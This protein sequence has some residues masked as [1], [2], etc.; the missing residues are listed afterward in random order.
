MVRRLPLVTDHHL[1]WPEQPGPLLPPILVE[2]PAWYTWL[3]AEPNR[4]FT[5][6]NQ[7]GT[8]TVRCEQRRQACYWYAY[9]KHQGRLH[10]AYLG[11]TEALTLA[12]LNAVTAELAS[13]STLRPGVMFSGPEP[14]ARARPRRAARPDHPRRARSAGPATFT[15]SPAAGFRGQ[16]HLPVPLTPLIGREQDVQA[17]ATLLRRSDIRL[18]TLTGAGGIGKTRLA[19]QVAASVLPDFADG[20]CYVSLAL[21]HD[22]AL[23]L[24][25][26]A[27]TLGL[28]EMGNRAEPAS[29]HAQLG[30]QQLLLVL[31]NFEQVVDAA[32]LLVELVGN[33]PQ[34]TILVTSRSI[35]R[36]PGEQEYPVAPLALPDLGHPADPA[37]LT[38]YAAVALF[39]ARAQ[40]RQ[41]AFQMTSANAGPIAEICIRL[42]GLP[43]AIELA[44][45]RVNVLTPEQI[46]ARLNDACRLLTGGART[47]LPRQQ[48]LRATLDWSYRLLTE[49]EQTVFRRLC[50]FAG[51]W[52]LAAAEAICAGEGIGEEQILTLLTLLIDHSL[53]STVECGGEVRYRLLAIIQQYGQ[54]QQQALGEVVI[55][56]RR[57]RDWYLALAEQA[58]PELVSRHQAAWLARLEAEHDN[59]R[60]ALR[61]SLDQHEGDA[62]AQISAALWSFWLLRGYLSEGRQWLDQAVAARPAQAVVRARVLLA[63]GSI[64]GRLGDYQRATSL[65]EE[66]LALWRTLG[67]QQR[68]AFTLSSL[69]IGAQ[70]QGDYAQA[71]A[72][73]EESLALARAGGDPQTTAL[74]LTNLGLVVFY[75]GNH[76]RARTLSEQG[77]ALFQDVGDQRGSAAVLTNLGMLSLAQGDYEQARRRA[78][79]SLA[80]R[81]EVGDK[82][83]SAHTL[84]LL[85]HV[86]FAQGQYDQ[87]ATCYTESR[88]LRQELGEPDGVAAALEGLAAICAVGGK[89]Q[90]AARLLGAAET[91]REAGGVAVP[92]LERTFQERLRAR[93]QAHLGVRAFAAACAEGRQLP[94]DQA[95]AYQVPPAAAPPS[96]PDGLT[97]REVE[98]LRLVAQ[99]LSD[100]RVATQLVIS[101]R[102]VQGHLRSIYNKISVNSRSAATRYALE[103]QLL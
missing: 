1:C 68:L 37:H 54:E 51:G 72:R 33:C 41:P 80:L 76:A 50:V 84:A 6:R 43:L 7:A 99:G 48:T 69:G 5:F 22:P 85:G 83:G 21:I 60:A 11:K 71:A 29:L 27:Q 47:A 90:N 77:L 13:R 66:S 96:P 95:L 89:A 97:A 32:P 44:A 20:V 67:D 55:W 75:Q 15:R 94:L 65:L 25:T 23:L 28:R 64:T 61:W 82:G 57:H 73:F 46:L 103:H 39:L 45:Q 74:V 35:L 10:K 53:V 59:L 81:R 12:R 9:R 24:P 16:Q 101:P 31:D 86:A 14:A 92:P 19:E 49:Q 42:D 40:A 38:Q 52:T 18:L 62:A 91:L 8:C 26:I 79:E 4:S 78:T 3:G 34:L 100:H 58:E 98:V 36:V 87:A 63:A 30:P 70:R 56:H 102:T 2:S 17:V 88:A 93:V